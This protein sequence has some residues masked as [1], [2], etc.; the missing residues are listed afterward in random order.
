MLNGSCG[1]CCIGY[2]LRVESFSGYDIMDKGRE[3]VPVLALWGLVTF[4]EIG[5][6]AFVVSRLLL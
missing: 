4:T 1:S 6:W 3:P 5:G 2:L